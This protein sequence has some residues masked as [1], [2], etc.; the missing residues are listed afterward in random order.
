[1]AG[2]GD[3]VDE[4]RSFG[5][6]YLLANLCEI[7][8]DL[9]VLQETCHSAVENNTVRIFVLTLPLSVGH[10]AQVAEYVDTLDLVASL[11]HGEASE[12]VFDCLF[13]TGL[14]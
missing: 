7:H 4:P 9:I 1:V 8:L 5:V 10:I 13:N 6:V 14:I 3:G 11:D 2:R 12:L